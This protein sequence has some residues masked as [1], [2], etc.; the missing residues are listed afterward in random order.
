MLGN[1]ILKIRYNNNIQLTDNCSIIKN[2]NRNNSQF[3]IISN[4]QTLTT[5]NS[6][7]NHLSN[8]KNIK[9]K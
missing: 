4:H 9:N 7:I 1:G 2:K 8:I 5:M 3:P 6:S